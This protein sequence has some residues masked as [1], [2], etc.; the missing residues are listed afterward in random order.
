MAAT[1]H[2]PTWSSD[3]GQ[4][5]R[6]ESQRQLEPMPQQVASLHDVVPVE[7]TESEHVA[8]Y[9]S[10]VHENGS[11]LHCVSVAFGQP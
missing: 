6:D 11:H 7:S 4:L 8:P 3:P 10:G 2:V 9:V 5:S 1:V